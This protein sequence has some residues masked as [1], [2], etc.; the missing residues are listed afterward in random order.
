MSFSI[1]WI[2]QAV[3]LTILHTVAPGE[4]YLGK[5]NDGPSV[6]RVSDH[7][8]YLLR[9]GQS[10]PIIMRSPPQIFLTQHGQKFITLF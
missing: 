6:H 2:L 5:R 3:P 9:G 10:W 1:F 4:T 7:F 8:D